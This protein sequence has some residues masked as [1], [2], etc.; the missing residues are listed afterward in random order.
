MLNFTSQGARTSPP[1]D[2]SLRQKVKV[3]LTGVRIPKPANN[4]TPDEWGLPFEVHKLKLNNLIQVESWYIPHPQVQCPTLML[5]GTNDPRAT[6]EE[7]RAIF[8]RLR[9]PKQ[10]VTFAEAGHEPYLATQPDRWQQ[11]VS[12]F[13]AEVRD[14]VKRGGA[15]K[16]E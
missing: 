15:G 9:G 11:A 14:T 8:H 16:G 3:L 5:H 7:G 10:F 12:E 4:S 2:L 1:E 6:L 13:L